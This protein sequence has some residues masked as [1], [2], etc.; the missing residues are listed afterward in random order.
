MISFLVEVV[1]IA[2]QPR[3]CNTQSVSCV[4]DPFTGDSYF[5]AIIKKARL[6]DAR[7]WFSS[8]SQC[9]IRY[10]SF[11]CFCFK[12]L[13][14]REAFWTSSQNNHVS[15]TMIPFWQE[16]MSGWLKLDSRSTLS[17]LMC[18]EHCLPRPQGILKA[19]SWQLQCVTVDEILG[20]GGVV[21]MSSTPF[22]PK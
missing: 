20:G 22:V 7:C 9:T 6:V 3:D 10:S 2:S 17:G 8:W 1:F 11:L 18:C 14:H 16:W 5:Y 4:S 19:S 12:Q 13:L 21:V 15:D